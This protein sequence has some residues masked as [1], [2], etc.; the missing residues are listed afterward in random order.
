LKAIKKIIPIV[1][2][3][4]IALVVVLYFKGRG[5]QGSADSLTTTG[6]IEATE[7]ALSPKISERIEWLCCAVGGKVRA[8]QV[9]ARLDARE[10]K[11]LVA[12][13]RATVAAS[14][15]AVKEARVELEIRRVAVESVGFAVEAARSEVARVESMAIDTEKEFKRIQSLVKKGF[16]SKSAFDSAKASYDSAAASL[17]SARS[18]LKA[19]EA[20]L[21]NARVAVK[22]AVAA[23]SAAKARRL[24]DEATVD[25]LATRLSY[26][27]LKTP[28][29]GV[30]SYKAFEAG[31]MAVPGRAIYTIYDFKD[32][33]A[34][35]DV[36]ETQLAD[37]R[38]GAKAEVWTA[39]E[40]ERVFKARVSE[41]GQMG[42]FATHKDVVRVSHD[43]KTFR[44]KVKLNAPEGLLKPGMTCKVKI[45]FGASANN[46]PGQPLKEA[47]K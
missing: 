27:I 29:D 28:I 17:D 35:L 31:E 3:V 2:L 5:Q 19:E 13:A 7:V 9:V 47:T 24:K 45:A 44:V 32:I 15:E 16:V 6:T 18:K 40:P 25:V 43:I 21:R 46:D 41:I 10:L 26:A 12:E 37:I 38:L 33:W 39:G 22:R 36:G 11:A 4:A 14:S 8:G 23:V 42:E 1:I 20:R 30:V 34:R